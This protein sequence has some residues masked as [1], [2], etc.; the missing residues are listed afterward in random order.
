MKK[1]L[2]STLAFSL[3]GWSASAQNVNIP[4]AN[5]KAY[6]VG[7]PVIN[8]NMDTEIQVSEAS[9][10]NGTIS[11]PNQSIADLTGIE[12]FVSLNILICSYND[13]TSLNLTQNTALTQVHLV[14]NDLT[15]LDVSQCTALNI[16]N[17][18]GNAIST[19]DLSA[20]TNLVELH[21]NYNSLSTLDLSQNTALTFLAI[22]GNLFSNL[23]LSANTDLEILFCGDNP[24][25]T[26]LDLS[27]NTSIESINGNFVVQGSLSTIILGQNS[28]LTFFNCENT[29]L[30]SLDISQCPNITQLNIPHNHLTSLD[31]SSNTALNN[32]NVTNNELTA[33]D[34]STNPTMSFIACSQNLLSELNLKNL[35]TATSLYATE[36]P[37]LTCIEVDDTT[38]AIANW[39]NI[40]PIASFSLDCDPNP[41]TS[42]VDAELAEKF[43]IYPNPVEADLHLSTQENVH[44]IEIMDVFG[45]SHQAN[46]SLNTVDVSA[47]AHGIYILRINTPN[48]TVTKRFVKK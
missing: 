13:L 4:D 2:L 19:I 6:L 3:L 25:L 46:I 10:Y 23:D 15:T 29:G 14:S 9:A 20:C 1:T 34:F 42:V 35:T 33:L 47:L 18:Q 8:T 12:A 43:A 21:C 41:G 17:F 30:T 37:N 7:N 26:T 45:K 40:D 32:V 39:T 36:N 48:G 44:S 27:N 38:D 31:L 24:N 11:C 28:N 22:N 16:L 5:F